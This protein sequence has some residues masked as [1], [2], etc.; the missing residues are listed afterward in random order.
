MVR[1]RQG[2][3]FQGRFGREEE[4]QAPRDEAGTDDGRTRVHL[5]RSR[6]VERQGSGVRAL[7]V[8]AVLLVL[9]LAA[10]AALG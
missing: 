3:R 10:M 9:V 4:D 8:F 7:I 1:L 5:R 2:G 6:T